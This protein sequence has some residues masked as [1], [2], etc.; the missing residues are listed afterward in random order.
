MELHPFSF[1]NHLM[2]KN[3]PGG[4]WG[5]HGNLFIILN[6]PYEGNTHLKHPQTI[7]VWDC[8]N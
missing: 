3:W 7:K 5:V 6:H 1:S 8:I 4:R 2:L